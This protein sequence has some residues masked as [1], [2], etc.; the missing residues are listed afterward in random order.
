MFSKKL[1][2]SRKQ[3]GLTQSQLVARL[4]E[5]QVKVSQ[6]SLSQWEKGNQLPSPDKSLLYRALAEVLDVPVEELIEAYQ[7][8]S[9][10]MDV[11]GIPESQVLQDAQKF[12]Q[13]HNHELDIW[14]L[15]PSMLP[16]MESQA[17][18]DAWVEN[19]NKGASYYILWFLDVVDIPRLRELEA[20]LAK[21]E[22]QVSAGAGEIYHLCSYAHAENSTYVAAS[23]IFEQ[24]RKSCSDPQSKGCHLRNQLHHL[25]SYSSPVTERM[26]DEFRIKILTYWQKFTSIVIYAPKAPFEDACAT[27]RLNDIS[28]QPNGRKLSPYFWFSVAQANEMRVD[29]EQYKHMLEEVAER[30]DAAG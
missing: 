25:A 24:S 19:L 9:R 12:V 3:V 2:A 28:D 13:G 16:V 21:V 30:E 29:L 20:V 8:Q 11:I 7:S 26:L 5:K 23:Y 27:I 1:S 10:S 18:R 17:V 14:V 15:G 6:A 22:E 4:A